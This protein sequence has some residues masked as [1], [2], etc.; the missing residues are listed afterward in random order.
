MGGF[1]FSKVLINWNLR[2]NGN[3][4]HHLCLLLELVVAEMERD[5]NIPEKVLTWPIHNGIKSFSSHGFE[6]M[7]TTISRDILK[8]TKKYYYACRIQQLILK[9]QI[10]NFHKFFSP[11]EFDNKTIITILHSNRN[12]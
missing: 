9:L 4:I 1:S 2:L 3:L 7:Y 8:V 12:T 11:S 10:L 5:N 6:I